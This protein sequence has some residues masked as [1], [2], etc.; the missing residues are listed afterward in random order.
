MDHMYRIVREKVELR[1]VSK[2]DMQTLLDWRNKDEIRNGFI[3]SEKITM[4]DHLKWFERYLNKPGDIMFI[5]EENSLLNKPVGS[6]ALYD[7][8]QDSETAEF[9]RLMI[10]EPEAKGKGIA[11]SATFLLCEFGFRELQLKSVYLEVFSDNFTAFKLYERSGFRK[12][13]ER[14]HQGRTLVKMTLLRDEL[15]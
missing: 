13:G 4:A 15:M 7:I 9:G 14:D 3:Q 8:D 2:D 6:I 12:V 1:P 11:K 10:G 5:I